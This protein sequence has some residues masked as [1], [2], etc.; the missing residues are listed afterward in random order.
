MWRYVNFSED[1]SVVY[2]FPKTKTLPNIMK[3]VP[4]PKQ[5]T[6]GLGFFKFP[7]NWNISRYVIVTEAEIIISII[8]F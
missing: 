8:S 2:S 1:C 4:N 5:G 3:I 7:E 6:F